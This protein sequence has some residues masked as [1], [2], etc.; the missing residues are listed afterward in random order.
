[1]T[2][3][4]GSVSYSYDALSRLTSETRQFSGLTGSY[5]LSYIYNLAGELTRV[6]DPTGAQVN[7]VY[8]ALVQMLKRDDN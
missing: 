3:G 2:D 7:Y 4:S 8:E 1:M 5:A 6:T